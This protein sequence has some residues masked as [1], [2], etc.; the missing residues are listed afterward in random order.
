[1]SRYALTV[2]PASIDFDTIRGDD[3]SIRLT[4]YVEGLDV[5]D[6]IQSLTACLRRFRQSLGI[7]SARPWRPNQEGF[8]TALELNY[9]EDTAA[10][11]L[12]CHQRTLRTLMMHIFT[13]DAMTP[14]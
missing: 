7:S 13:D 11:A 1:M 14:F 2:R 12:G 10:F 8:V 6:A 3:L 5:E 9:L 4:D